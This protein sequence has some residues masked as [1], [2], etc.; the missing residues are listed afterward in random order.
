MSLVAPS[1][2]VL[3]FGKEGDCLWS[4]YSNSMKIFQATMEKTQGIFFDVRGFKLLCVGHKYPWTVSFP[5]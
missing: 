3:D 1:T 2:K 5:S 4:S